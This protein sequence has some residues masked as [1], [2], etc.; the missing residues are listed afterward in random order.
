MKYI[1][2]VNI[3][4]G[5]KSDM[6]FSCGNTLPLVQMPHGMV[7][8]APQS[9]GKTAWWY[10]PQARW[11]EGVRLTHQPSP[12][13]GDYGTLL[14]T[15]QS[16]FVNDTYEQAY[17][18]I[19][20]ED[21]ILKP[22]YMKINFI[23]SKSTFELTPGERSA[24]VRVKFGRRTNNCISVFNIIGSG[25]FKQSGTAVSGYT[26]GY[27]QGQPI[28]F[29]MYFTLKMRGGSFEK[30]VIKN[31]GEKNAAVHCYLKDGVQEAVFDISVSY[32]SAEQAEKNGLS[33]CKMSFEEIYSEC[34]GAWENYLSKIKIDENEAVMKTFYSCLYRTAV[35][36]H[37][38]YEIADGS[39]KFYNP[40]KNEV[41]SG[42]RYTGIGMWDAYRTLFPLYAL[43]DREFYRELLES[44][45]NE[46]LIS[47][48][49]PRWI[50]ASEVGCMPSTLIDAVIADAAAKNIVERDLLEKLFAAMEKHANKKSEKRIFAREGI[51]DYIKL[52]YVPCDKYKESVNLTLDFS[53][54]DWC[55]G[56][57][58]HLLGYEEKAKKYLKRAE[59]YKNL[60]DE[61]SGFM[62]AKKENGE[63]RENF[64]PISWDGDYT[65][66]SAYQTFFSPVHD[67]ENLAALV[68]GKEQLIKRLDELF[69]H[70][71][72]YRVGGYET[73]I[74]EMT[75]MASASFG[76]C[77]ISNQPS[78][79]IPFIYAYFGENEKTQYWAKKI[80]LEAF[81]YKSDGFPGDED[82]GSMSAWYI[83]AS[84]GFYPICPGKN[85]YVFFN[86]V[87]DNADIC[88]T[89][90]K[91]LKGRLKN[92]G[93]EK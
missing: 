70:E 60:F 19:N 40:Y 27:V 50:G 20:P 14:F 84:L 59:N 42:V 85:E 74:H 73:E 53:Y 37:K 31:S 80:C 92:F 22:N 3:K 32:I 51:E 64:D 90:L 62:R 12:W 79:A 4:Q 65:E 66:S 35:Y 87:I 86:S 61:K 17:S 25:F 76:L 43:I 72:D 46:Y 54:G 82:N 83:F 48:W 58:A 13:I 8:F 71:S 33:T 21:V 47:G 77:A 56:S 44:F 18:G 63:L 55:I 68:G 2:Y 28:D 11:C 89:S 36:P 78:F 93:A 23:R 7:S 49:L 57:L 1:D 81:S 91:K 10:N 39:A 5:T 29:K 16:D 67:L 15:V 45:Y 30:V 38:A 6:R 69:E 75:E 9:G 88:G 26:T 24:A 52:G 41:C 34:E